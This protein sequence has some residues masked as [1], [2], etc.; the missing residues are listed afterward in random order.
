MIADALSGLVLFVFVT[1]A[2]LVL[3]VVIFL[4]ACMCVAGYVW[5]RLIGG[6]RA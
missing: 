3:G 6:R 4:S 2:V 5:Q 1:M